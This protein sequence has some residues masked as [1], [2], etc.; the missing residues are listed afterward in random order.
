MNLVP[1]IKLND[2]HDIPQLGLGTYQID[3]KDTK[4]SVL[5]AFKI[6]YRHIDTAE[7]YGNERE[8]G[9]ALKASGL[10]RSEVFI[11]SKLNNGFHEPDSARAAFAETLKKLDVEYID[12]FLIRTYG[13]PCRNVASYFESPI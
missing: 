11:T 1:Q 4:E 7:M 6:G 9:E 13:D 12:L 10:D 5:T 2:G 3:P 8:V